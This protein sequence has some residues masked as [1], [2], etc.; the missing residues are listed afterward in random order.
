MKK[1]ITI[2]VLA[3]LLLLSWAYIIGS[4]F[5]LRR[6]GWTLTKYAV[7]NIP[8]DDQWSMMI[9]N[10]AH[11]FAVHSSGL[12]PEFDAVLGPSGRARFGFRNAKVSYLDEDGDGVVDI[13]WA[14]GQEYAMQKPVWIVK[15]KSE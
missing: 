12:H 5:Q 13:M 1:N 14:N 8:R 9:I 10:S 4:P 3:F 7:I 2:T 6:G 15:Q 11:G